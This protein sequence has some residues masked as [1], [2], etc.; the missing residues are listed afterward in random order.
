[1]NM[2]KIKTISLTILFIF[3]AIIS[4]AQVY[5]HNNYSEPVLVAIAYYS[6]SSDFKGYYSSGF[7]RVDPNDKVTLL[8]GGL[9][10]YSPVYYYV[11]TVSGKTFDGGT[12]SFLVDPNNAFT[13]KNANEQY[14]QTEN[15]TYQWYSF[16][17]EPFSGLWHTIEFNY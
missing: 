13:I 7:Y 10:L 1:M 8:Q 6:S 9:G 14:V 5:F 11:K 4:K 15:P 3:G 2:K 12:T 16:R 17:Q